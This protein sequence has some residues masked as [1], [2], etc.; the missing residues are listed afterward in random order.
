MHTAYRH[1]GPTFRAAVRQICT[2][3]LSTREQHEDLI[4]GLSYA[5]VRLGAA[6]G[7]RTEPERDAA[8]A[9]AVGTLDALIDDSDEFEAAIERVFATAVASA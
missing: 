6:G 5:L 3:D 8:L 7:L 2:E 1:R 4:A 9:M